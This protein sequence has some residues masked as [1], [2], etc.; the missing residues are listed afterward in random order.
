MI[1]VKSPVSKIQAFDYNGKNALFFASA[2]GWVRGIDENGVSLF[3]AQ[4]SEVALENLL[5]PFVTDF[6]FDGY[7]EVIHPHEQT[8]S[9]YGLAAGDLDLASPEQA[10]ISEEIVGFVDQNNGNGSVLLH[11]GEKAYFFSKLDLENFSNLRPTYQK[12]EAQSNHHDWMTVNVDGN[13][14]KDLV[15]IN[16]DYV[17]VNFF[18]EYSAKS[19]Q[20][21]NQFSFIGYDQPSTPLII[22]D[23]DGDDQLEII[24]GTSPV[25]HYIE[26]R[27]Y[28]LDAN[29]GKVEHILG[30]ES[31][32]LGDNIWFGEIWGENYLSYVSG[33]SMTI[34]EASYFNL[35]RE[36]CGD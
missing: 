8:V 33:D 26:G 7:A 18:G 13:T 25:G 24:V 11:S 29:T 28:V 35:S 32:L 23:V 5:P 3:A 6:D 30:A 1:D 17:G 16:N 15:Y 31:D 9:I 34:I 14:V 36:N 22:K 12:V 19:W 20:F 21:K 4:H 2:D 27:I 10:M